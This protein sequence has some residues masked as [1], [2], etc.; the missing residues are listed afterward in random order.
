MTDIRKYCLRNPVPKEK[1]GPRTAVRRNPLSAG[2]AWSPDDS[3]TQAISRGQRKVARAKR[4]LLQ[5][6][7]EDIT[8][9]T[10]TKK[11]VTK[12]TVAKK[13]PAKKAAA[14]KSQTL[15]QILPDGYD[16]RKARRILR[17]SD[18][19]KEMGERWEFTPAQR[20]KALELLQG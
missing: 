17:K 2:W 6:N 12:K 15:K 13:S 4:R 5:S 16:P 1:A 9:A 8:M 20:D 19:A 11:T 7:N 10:A 18:L 14:K 3:T